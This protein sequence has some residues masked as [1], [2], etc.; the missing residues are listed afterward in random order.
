MGWWRPSK[1][2]DGDVDQVFGA[3][4]ANGAVALSRSGEIGLPFRTARGS[5]PILGS[6]RLW[7]SPFKSL[8][9]GL[10]SWVI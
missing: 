1:H 9:S 4:M 8:N 7:Q 2:P 5:M 10:T 3:A 6:E